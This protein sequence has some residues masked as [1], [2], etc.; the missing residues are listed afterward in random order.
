M[1]GNFNQ[2]AGTMIQEGDKIYQDTLRK[3]NN[4]VQEK[5]ALRNSAWQNIGAG[6]N[7]LT[8]LAAQYGGDIG[9]LRM[10]K[11]FTPN[12]GIA[13]LDSG[14]NTIGAFGN[15]KAPVNYNPAW[16]K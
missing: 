4:A 10:K 6:V 5:S 14:P 16:M 13:D 1:L 15:I 8:G 2:A 11:G 7:G 3:Y 9:K 12:M